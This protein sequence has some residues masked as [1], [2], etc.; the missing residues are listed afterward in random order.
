MSRVNPE[1][2]KQRLLYCTF[3]LCNVSRVDEDEIDVRVS[4]NRLKLTCSRK[5]ELDIYLPVKV[6]ADEIKGNSWD[7]DSHVLEIVLVIL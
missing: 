7:A 3:N 5:Y 2:V 4:K 1:N 6:D